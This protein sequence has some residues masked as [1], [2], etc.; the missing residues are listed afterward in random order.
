M[1][2]EQDN[3]DFENTAWERQGSHLY[4]V[5]GASAHMYYV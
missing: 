2:V 5:K 3:Y 1:T 4:V